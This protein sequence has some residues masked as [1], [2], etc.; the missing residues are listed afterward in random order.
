MCVRGGQ[1]QLTDRP[2]VPDVIP[3]KSHLSL[4]PH[5]REGSSVSMGSHCRCRK[6]PIHST[7][8]ETLMEA[9][10]RQF[11]RRCTTWD[12][13]EKAEASGDQL[14]FCLSLI[15]LLTVFMAISVRPL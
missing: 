13:T 5:L 8:R 12:G 9:N 14:E 7:G 2:L 15:V 3:K 4:K 10:L 1:R 6:R 11:P